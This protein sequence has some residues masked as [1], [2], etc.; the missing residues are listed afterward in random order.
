MK[1]HIL[2]VICWA[3]CVCEV[4]SP[5]LHIIAFFIAVCMCLCNKLHTWMHQN[6]IEHY[7]HTIIAGCVSG[8]SSSTDRNSVRRTYFYWRIAHQSR[9]NH[10]AHNDWYFALR[11]AITS[12]FAP[13][14]ANII[15]ETC[16]C[17]MTLSSAKWHPFIPY[18]LHANIHFD[19]VLCTFPYA[20]MYTTEKT[21]SSL[22]SFS[23]CRSLSLLKRARCLRSSCVRGKA[24]SN[25]ASF[26]FNQHKLMKEKFDFLL[27]LA[28]HL[29]C[30]CQNTLCSFSFIP[31]AWMNEK[32][33]EW[34][35]VKGKSC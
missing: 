29:H 35:K 28:K 13:S 1:R 10:S 12:V 18:K 24:Q 32:T 27:F 7:C 14:N 22:R 2:F 16:N 9:K 17:Q 5:H 6:G 4:T 34:A 20:H 25:K 11:S 23:L 33:T 26:H 30:Q 19:N 8:S 31:S 3:H 15:S 21:S